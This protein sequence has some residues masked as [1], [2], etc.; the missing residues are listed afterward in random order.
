MML[1]KSWENFLSW[2]LLLNYQSIKLARSMYKKSAF[3]H[4]MV[5]HF[6]KNFS[7]LLKLL[8]KISQK[9]IKK[10]KDKFLF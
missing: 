2:Q 7:D 4:Q 6:G 1:G 5:K 8:K 3:L 9:H 10:I